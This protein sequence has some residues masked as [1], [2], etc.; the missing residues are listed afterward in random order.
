LYSEWP[1][2]DELRP[3]VYD[4]HARKWRLIDADERAL[5]A[6]SPDRRPGER[7]GSSWSFIQRARG[8][9]ARWGLP[10]VNGL[11]GGNAGFIT[12][13]LF[14]KE[15][16]IDRFEQCRQFVNGP[17]VTVFHDMI[18]LQ[19]PEISP[20]KTVLFY[21]EYLEKLLLFD[22]IAANSEYSRDVL[23]EYWRK[24]GVS[25][26]PQILACPLGVD[27][28]PRHVIPLCDNITD[29]TRPVGP[30]LASGR[31]LLVCLPRERGLTQ[32][33][34]LQN[35]RLRNISNT[36]ENINAKDN[37]LILS[38]GTFEGRKNQV[39]LLAACKMLWQKGA[40]FRLRLVGILN[41]ETGRDAKRAF[42]E[43]YAE[44]FP[45]EWWNAASDEDLVASYAACHFTVYPSLH[46][47]FGLPVLESLAH[48]RPC[49]CSGLN[50]MAEIV[51]DGGCIA[52]GEPT[53]ENLAQG[54]ERMLSNP[55]LW[56]K[57]CAETTARE[58]RSWSDYA[59]T[60]R[61]LMLAEKAHYCPDR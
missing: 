21:K 59:D 5:L 41:R 53:A 52:V 36:S 35:L 29:V 31:E 1:E 43:L 3:V 55:V 61:N 46:E 48:G 19:Y 34:T 30:D 18:A 6:F 9:F 58:I 38:V 47:G 44:G 17:L 37:P 50:A 39:A 10:C 28:P 51:R 14:G 13:E 7:R 25:T 8:K 57:L 56:K 60:F 32:G 23:T 45:L 16:T 42:D 20:R 33:Q 26:T 4:T 15:R 49:V 24:Q 40:H 11:P 12:V 27:L 22:L 54:I 2:K